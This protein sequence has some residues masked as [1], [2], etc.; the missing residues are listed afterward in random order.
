[1]IPSSRTLKYKNLLGGIFMSRKS[2]IEPV[3]KVKIVEQYLR[4]EIGLNEARRLAGISSNNDMLAWVRIYEIAGPT[5]LLKQP[6]NQSYSRELKLNAVHDYLN[7][8]GSLNDICN[9]Y[10][11][12]Y[13]SQL[14]QWIKV[15]NTGRSLKEST[16]G[17][18]MRKA[19][20]TMPE[21]R[22]KI[23]KDCLENDKKL[24]SNCN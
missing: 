22:L 11:I 6:Q 8:T 16:G 10:E 21:E 15:Y 3:E 13:R 23:V 14:R 1:M 18:S 19:R 12:R 2:K 4:R 9:K 24:W 7:G 5:G 20:A 17:A